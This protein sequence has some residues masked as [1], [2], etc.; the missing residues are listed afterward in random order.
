MT[1]CLAAFAAY[2]S[3]N[4]GVCRFD[5]GL[6]SVGLRHDLAGLEGFF[7]SHVPLRVD[8]ELAQS[9]REFFGRVREQADLVKRHQTYARD[10]MARYPVFRSTPS[11]RETLSIIVEQVEKLD[12]Y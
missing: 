9:F 10:V 12:D 5:I 8:L 3:R 1:S 7:A 2:L 6:S 11:L 4:T